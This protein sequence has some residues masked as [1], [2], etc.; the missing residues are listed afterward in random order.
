MADQ[1]PE[2]A[3]GLGRAFSCTT[4][5]LCTFLRRKA[6]RREGDKCFFAPF[7][8][9]EQFWPVSHLSKARLYYSIRYMTTGLPQ[10][11]KGAMIE[12]SQDVGW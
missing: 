9:L 4:H 11:M 1:L 12:P 10:V 3:A 7:F 8:I 2:P 6:R 5:G